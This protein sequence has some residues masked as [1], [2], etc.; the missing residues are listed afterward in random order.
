MNIGEAMRIVLSGPGNIEYHFN[1]LLQISKEDLDEHILNITR[2]LLN[3]ELVLLPDKGISLEIAKKYKELNG[4][5]VIATL[6]KEDYEIGIDHLKTNLN[7]DIWDEIINT[8]TWYKHDLMHNLF[9]DVILYLGNSLGSIGE[10]AYGFYLYKLLGKNTIKL[11]SE[12][13]AGQ[14]IPFIVL[15]YKPFVKEKLSFE[16]EEYIKKAQGQIFYIENAEEL[17][18]KLNDLKTKIKI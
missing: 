4:K 9:G 13:K 3:D 5:R 18:D 10:L 17:K 12:I 8:K 16:L 14:S 2:V 7:L 11:N 6:P 1:E 15:V